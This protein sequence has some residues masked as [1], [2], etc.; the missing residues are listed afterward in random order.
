MEP[1]TNLKEILSLDEIK[2]LVNTFYSRVRADNLLAPIFE[3]KIGDKWDKHLDTMYRFW[4]TVLLEDHT[5]HGSP[6]L[7]HIGLPV[8]K[9]HF[10]RWI[11]IFQQ[12]L[13][14]HFTG[15]VAMEARWRANRMAEMFA[16]K[17]A[18]FKNNPGAIQ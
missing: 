13:D 3:E 11:S 10:E 9:I 8:D 18:F 12:T 7:K 1:K 6:L 15:E 5:Y 14:D 4:Q 16:Y 2:L 17:L